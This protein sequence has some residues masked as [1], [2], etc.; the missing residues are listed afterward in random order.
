ME[1]TVDD[2]EEPEDPHE[3]SSE[4]VAAFVRSLGPAEYFSLPEIK[5]CNLE[6]IHTP[7]YTPL[8]TPLFHPGETFDSLR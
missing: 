7:L 5:C 1:D 4:E 6:W 8:M 3:W 2:S